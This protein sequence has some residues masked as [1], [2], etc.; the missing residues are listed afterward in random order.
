[1]IS[2]IR[3]YRIFGKTAVLFLYC[4]YSVLPEEANLSHRQRTGGMFGN[5]ILRVEGTTWQL[6]EKFT[7]CTREDPPCEATAVCIIRQIDGR[8]GNEVMV[9]LRM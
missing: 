7:E 2:K 8:I 1:M 5:G 6:V 4:H 3:L 9:K